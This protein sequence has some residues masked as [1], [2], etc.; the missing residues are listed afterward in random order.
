MEYVL[1]RFFLPSL[2]VREFWS[3]FA[4][5]IHD[6]FIP[7]HRNNYHPHLLSNRALGLFSIG[8]VSVKVFT[9]AIVSLGAAIPAFSSAITSENIISLTNSSRTEYNL[10]ALTSNTVLAQ[11]AQ[12]KAENMLEEGYFAHNSPSGATPWDFIRAQDYNYIVAGENLAVNFIQAESVSQ[13]WMNSPSHKAN[14][15]NK[16]YEEIGIGIASGVFQGR[17]ATLV[18][19][20]FGTPALQPISVLP[21]ATK[22]QQAS[23]PVP[24]E[25]QNKVEVLDSSFTQAGESLLISAKLS[26]GA[27]KAVVTFGEKAIMLNPKEENLW[28]GSVPLASLENS[29]LNLTVTDIN[30]TEI[31]QNLGSF[32]GSTVES[33]NVL[34]ASEEGTATWLGETFSPKSF[35]QKVYLIFIAG[36]LA[37]LILAIAIKRHIQHVGLIANSS[38]VIILALM[39]WM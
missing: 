37:S 5:H 23:V 27:V 10:V 18:V 13:A 30:N 11:A 28:E 7:H 38:F 16:N 34:G 25:I 3:G 14:I 31:S 29:K 22:I 4:E 8:L 32:A 36:V 20:M 35:E 17:Q 39:L 12:A 6:H 33:F 21:E 15:L 1:R 24:S 9:I 19:Q 2:G 26:T